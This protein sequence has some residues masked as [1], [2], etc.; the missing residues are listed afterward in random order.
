MDIVRYRVFQTTIQVETSS[1]NPSL[2]FSKMDANNTALMVIDVINSCAHEKCEIA[3]WDIRFTRVRAMV[4]RLQKF[5]E[6][7][8]RVVGGPVVFVKTVPWQRQYLADNINQLYE[9]PGVCYYT[10][11]TSGFAEEF[12]CVQPEQSDLLIVKNH[13]DAFANA[14]LIREAG[15]RGLEYFAVTG[16][17]TDGCVLATV[18]GGFSRGYNF[19]VLRD[20]VETTD[21]KERQQLQAL[22]LRTTFPQLFARVIA[23]D[24]FLRAWDGG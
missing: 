13:V 23:S 15:Q 8:R 19:V 7:Y 14:D 3:K 9:D 17:F 21:V 1:M 11:D 2:L 24:K 5:I 20:L 18:A 4:P 12:Y 16:I 10:E 6:G 22:M